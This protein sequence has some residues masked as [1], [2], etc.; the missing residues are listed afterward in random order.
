MSADAITAKF[1]TTKFGFRIRTR[2]GLLVE[3][4]SIHGRD[5]AHAEEKLRQMYQHCEIIDRQVLQSRAV[6]AFPQA[7]KAAQRA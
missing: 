3:H 7:F 1:V 2:H 4:L 6:S 5:E